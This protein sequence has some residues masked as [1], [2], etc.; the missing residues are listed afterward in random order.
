MTTGPSGVARAWRST[1]RLAITAWPAGALGR[2][3]VALAGA[4]CEGLL[5]ALALK[6]VVDGAGRG[7]HTAVAAWMI[8]LTASALAPGALSETF[9][10][11]QRGLFFHVS[12]ASTQAVM[13]A[14]LAPTGIAHLE[15]PRYADVMEVVRTRS[16][17]I[18]LLFDWLATTAAAVVSLGA[19]LVIL[20]RSQPILLL[21]VAGAGA[22]GMFQAGTRRRTLEF[23]E[24]SIPGQ[25]LAGRMIDLATAAASAPEVRMLGLAGWLS[26][27][28]RDLTGEVAHRMVQGERRAVLVS[29]AC[30]VFQ[31]LMLALGVGLLVHATVTGSASAGQLALGVVLLRATLD[32]ASRLGIMGAD[33]TKSTYLA[34]RFQWLIDYTPDVEV[35]AHP[36]ALPDRLGSGITLERVSF[37]YPG[38]DTP[39]LNDVSLTLPAGTTV[40]LVGDNGA[41]KSTIVKLLARFYDPTAGTISIDGVDLRQLDPQTWRAASTGAYQDFLQLHLLAAEAVGVGDLAHLH[42]QTRVA[43]AAQAGGAAPFLERL[44]AGYSTRL[45]RELDG[46]C[47]L[48][49]GQWQKVALSRGLMANEPLLVLL[50]EPTAALDARAEADLFDVYAAQA[51][52]AKERGAV[53][54]LVSHR[55]STVRSAD[56]IVVLDHGQVVESGSHDQLIATGGQYAQLYEL[57]AQRYRT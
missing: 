55:F 17:G 24:Q 23:M 10:Y 8:V 43:A 53:T 5:P 49:Q 50:D 28:H 31:A 14:S 48:S 54:V 45:G 35:P 39:V 18:A 16:E 41:G 19:G 40:A 36:R 26:G 4:L 46:G 38:T 6:R 12:Q 21:P 51:R 32:Q 52:A 44:P 34:Q 15:S 27:R 3:A 47:E 11:F 30:G 57:Q 2:P 20:A 7:D 9:R 42:D 13:V 25:R 29:L 37:T 56:L 1:A 33:I 22:V